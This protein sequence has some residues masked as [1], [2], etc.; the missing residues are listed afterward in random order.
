M[1]TNND[2]T[3][4]QAS[5]EDV[6]GC[7]AR[8]DA[9]VRAVLGRVMAQRRSA[10]TALDYIRGLAPEVKANCWG[11]AEA[12]GHQSPYRMQALLR[13]YRW[14]WKDLR[15]ELPA[16]ARAWLPCDPGDL[17]GPGIAVDETAQLKDGDAT[18]C[19]A[20]QHAGCTGHVENCVTTVFSAWVTTSG[21]AWADF[22][23][24]MP[25]RWEK[26]RRRRRAARIP[27]K[28][29][30]KTKPQL[31]IDQIGCL[32]AAGLPARWAAFDEVY[33]RSG[34]LRRF[35]ESRG[36]AYVAVV[37]RDFRITLP[38]GAVTRAG[39]TVRD[40]VFEQRS[41]GNG[42]KGPRLADWALLATSSPRH[43]LL[44][45]RL[46]SRPDDLAFYLCWAPEGT[47]ATMTVF[48][49][50]AGRRWPA[51]ETFKTGKD[52]LGWDQ[53]QARTWD[54]VCRHTAL[55]AL[56]QLRQAAVRSHLCSDITLPG[57]PAGASRDDSDHGDTGSD[58]GIPLG[59]APVPAR[60]GQPCPPRIAA[61]RLTIA[62]TA[63]IERLARQHAAGLITRARLAF[64]LRWSR[65]R[66][67]H[68]ARARWHHYSTRLQAAAAT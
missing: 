58:P 36:L 42:S 31:A 57:A 9:Q 60:G 2:D 50:I 11:L 45:R 25:E 33:G 47:P 28:L 37:P 39:D 51:E 22:D 59:D 53:C 63:R 54:A 10:G 7:S 35:C 30:R 20:P 56:A 46:I 55:A 14:D 38:S 21:Q 1:T 3:A 61:I 62:E 27:D 67:R 32:L 41:C 12:A 43:V 23:V 48:I 13:S 16:L 68:Q 40:A 4:V 49:T 15:A 6:S 8:A 44:I 34:A 24:F 64:C 17:I 19:V 52:V 29:E 66:R 26:D 5:I 18:A 65:W